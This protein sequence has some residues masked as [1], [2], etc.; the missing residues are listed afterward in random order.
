MQ[1]NKNIRWITGLTIA[2][3]LVAIYLVI[4]ELFSPGYC[5][6]Y[7]IIKVPACIVVLVLFIINLF[8]LFIKRRAVSR[9]LFYLS[10]LAGLFTATWFSSNHLLAKLSC[11]VLFTI[12]LCFLAFLCFGSLIILGIK[13]KKSAR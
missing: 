11:P 4:N 7:P 13:G 1:N 8:S 3:V 5:P 6:A 12:P 9:F 10:A 2:G